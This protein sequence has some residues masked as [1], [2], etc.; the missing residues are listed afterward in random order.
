MPRGKVETI[1]YLFSHASSR[2][3]FKALIY[4][5]TGLDLSR[6]I[7]LNRDADIYNDENYRQNI[8]LVKG[9]KIVI[10][11]ENNIR[12]N[13]IADNYISRIKQTGIILRDNYIKNPQITKLIFSR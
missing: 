8:V 7:P 4:Q 10:L 2:E 12:N 11:C 6:Y 3:V 13:K 5:K 9:N 1:K